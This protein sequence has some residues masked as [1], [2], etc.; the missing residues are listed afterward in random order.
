VARRRRRLRIHGR[1]YGQL[2]AVAPDKDLV[3][4]ITAHL[5]AATDATAVTRWLLETYILPRRA[6]RTEYP[7]RRHDP[8]LGGFDA[9]RSARCLI[10]RSIF[11]SITKEPGSIGIIPS[12][13]FSFVAGS[14]CG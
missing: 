6:L 5:P 3:A 7:R 11:R 9:S 1:L 12:L 2:A 8:P 14:G 13:S 4:V 10:P